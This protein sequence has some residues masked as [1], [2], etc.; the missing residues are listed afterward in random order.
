LVCKTAKN[1][2]K[3]VRFCFI[4][5]KRISNKAVIRNKLK[6]QLREAVMAQ[7]AR[8]NPGAD[9]VLIAYSGLETKKY[10]D[11]AMAVEKLLNKSGVLK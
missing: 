5:S 1:G 9:C 3:T 11:L 4:V 7:L 6:R 2:L 8:A 10:G